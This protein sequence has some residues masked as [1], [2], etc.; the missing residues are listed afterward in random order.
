MKFENIFIS[1]GVL[2]VD[3]VNDIFCQGDFAIV[4]LK[5]QTS[6]IS[7]VQVFLVTMKRKLIT[8][9]FYYVQEETFSSE[10]NL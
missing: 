8:F 2:R 1:W 5:I 7:Q 10:I 3:F 6:A 9:Q 4:T